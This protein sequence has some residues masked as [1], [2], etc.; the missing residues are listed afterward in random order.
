MGEQFVLSIDCGT[1]SIRAIIFDKDGKLIGK[2]KIGFEPYF[3][4]KPGWAE[5][6]PDVY[7]S[8]GCLACKKVKEMCPN[9][10]NN[11]GAVVVTTQRDTVINVDKNGNCLRPAIIWL[12]QRM[13]KC[14]EPLPFYNNL[15]F[16][17]VG[18]KK[19]IDIF[20]KQGKANWI[21][22]NQPEIWEKTYKYLLLSGY[23]SYKLCGKFVDSVG[24][25]IGHIPFDYKNRC[26]VKSNSNYKWGLFGIEREKLPELIEPGE[27]L[28]TI[29]HEASIE[30]GIKE[31][32]PL[33]AAGSD[34]G[35]ETLGNGCLTSSSASISFGTTATIQTTEK[36]YF[37][38]LQ[39]LPAY[40][41]SIPGY[42]NAEVEI[43]RGY[44]MISWFKKEFGLREMIKAKET[45][46]DPEVL[47]NGLLKEIPPGSQGLILNPYWGA[48]LKTPE[49][50]GAII[51]FGDVHTRAHTY[52]AI[53]EGINYGL[54]E[55][56]E[57]IEKK[58]GTK[59]ER[60]VVAGG[61][62][63]SDTICQITSDMFGKPIY[64]V[65][66]YETSA[67]GAAING[68]VGLGVFNKYMDAVNSMVHYVKTFEPDK[69][70]SEI[71]EKL[72]RKVYKK[73][74]PSLK[75]LYEEI[76]K[77]TEYPKY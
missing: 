17:S 53:I 69:K 50:K 64:K 11:V 54:I 27:L 68:F 8:N 35:C 59:I 57:R 3:S 19:S 33:I 24:C 52:R 76:Q 5:Q 74:Y 23:L 61:G 12:D 29:N 37:E 1:Q 38:A 56:A 47:L 58:S 22:E 66:T 34:K 77:I 4:A 70:N 46:V 7:W 63:Q 13:A 48:S 41:A 60:A 45:G 16:Y 30:T 44:W 42:Y 43:F 2:S 26:W 49:A 14:E 55:G 75:P 6:D 62:S 39:F 31:G 67:L 73:I 25:Q 36:R 21:K 9:E 20:R 71:Y 32:T 15:M 51:G 18:M 10:F 72:Y 28:G 40:P 65:H